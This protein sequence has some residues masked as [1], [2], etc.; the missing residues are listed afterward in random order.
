MTTSG[1]PRIAKRWKRGTSLSEAKVIY[2]GQP[3]DLSINAY[4]DDTKGFERH[5]VNRALAFYKNEMF[6][7]TPKGLQKID[8]PMDAMGSVVR[9]W[10]LVEPRTPWTIG[11][12]TYP[13]GCL[14]ATRFDGFMAGK[15]DFTV[16]YEPTPNSS[17]ES[18]TWTHHYLILNVLEDVKNRLTVLTPG[19][20][21][22]KREPFQGAP[23]FSTVSAWGI[24]PE[25][26]DDFFMNVSDFLRPPSLFIGRIGAM[27]EKI[28]EMPAFFD[29]S[30][31]EVS[32]HF[33]ASKDGTK[34]PYFQVSKKG[35]KLDG[36]NPTILDGYGGFEIS[37]APNYSGGMGRGWLSQGGVYVLANIRG[38]GEFGP[39]WHQA[40]LKENRQRVY[41]DFHAV[42]EDL[43][44]RKITSARHLG[45]M[46]GSNGG[47]LVGVAFTQRPELYGAVVCQVPLLDMQRYNK[48]LA[49]A[50]WMGEYGNPDKPEEWAYIQKYSPY[51]NLKKDMNYPEVFFYT[52]TRD[53]RVHPGHARKM[54]AKMMDM[55][56]PVLYYENTEGGHAGASTNEQTA[57]FSALQYSY[58]WMKL[59]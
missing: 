23:P 39:G 54:A 9:E 55:G 52:S 51:H 31:L 27:P 15:R 20:A 32:Q 16:L 41:D 50:S 30:G 5:F 13:A 29:A 7:E 34:V 48:L 11:G 26:S 42:A 3:T 24:D 36:S 33:A 43:I 19:K 46:G 28:K 4:F 8:I 10:L 12:K 59:K 35:M 22:W 38:G 49:G 14:I 6:L 2:E 47:L 25:E 53:D 21:E 57:K 58:L 56:F 1:Y 40:G 17:L 37:M 45:I 18:Y 44:K